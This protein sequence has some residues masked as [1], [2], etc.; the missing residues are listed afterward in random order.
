MRRF[1]I[2]GHSWTGGAGFLASIVV[3]HWSEV[4]ACTAAVATAAYMTLRAV[5]E[6]VKLRRELNTKERAD[7]SKW[8]GNSNCP[9]RKPVSA[10]DDED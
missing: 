10:D 3:S 7:E 9:N 2:D 4:A 6:W 5:R 8:C 1:G